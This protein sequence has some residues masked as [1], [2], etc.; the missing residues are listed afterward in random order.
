VRK[1]ANLLDPGSV[2]IHGAK[3]EKLQSR[4]ETVFTNL[5]NVST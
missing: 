5:K 4:S 2:E 3:E 1:K